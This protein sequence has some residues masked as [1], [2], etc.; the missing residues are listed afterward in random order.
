[1]SSHSRKAALGHLVAAAALAA[2]AQRAAAT[3]EARLTPA[4]VRRRRPD[5]VLGPGAPPPAPL[6][7]DL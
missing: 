6:L 5:R 2:L 1:M 7:G 3:P 4:L